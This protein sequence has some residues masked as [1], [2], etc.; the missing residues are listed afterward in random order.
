MKAVQYITPYSSMSP[1]DD[2]V[3]SKHVTTL[4]VI[5]TLNGVLMVF[6]EQQLASNSRS[7][8]KTLTDPVNWTNRTKKLKLKHSC[9]KD[10]LQYNE[11]EK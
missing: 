8:K 3:G 6:N 4:S 10:G 1:E 11:M 7:F 9:I 5:L 2:P